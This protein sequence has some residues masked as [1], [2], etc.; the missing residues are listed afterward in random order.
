VKRLIPWAG[1]PASGPPGARTRK[2]DAAQVSP[3]GGA[4][5]WRSPRQRR[6]GAR[7]PTWPARLC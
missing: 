6:L 3:G 5:R 1:S 7:I 4:H 2:K